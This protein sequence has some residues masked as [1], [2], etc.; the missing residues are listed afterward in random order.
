MNKYLSLFKNN[1]PRIK[2][3]SLYLS[4]SIVSGV[5]NVIF[6]PFLA[7]NLSSLDYSIIGY[8][9][10]F[11]SLFTPILNF[12]LISFYVR[13]YFKIPEE[14]RQLTLDTII[15]TLIIWGVI[16][17]ILILVLFYAYCNIAKVELPFFPFAVLVV[18]RLFF[19][20]F[21]LLYQVE[22]RMRREAKRYFKITILASLITILLSV[23]L[24]ILF[25][26]GAVGR[27]SAMLISSI[28]IGIFAIKKIHSKFKI[29]KSILKEAISFGWPVSC[30]YMIQYFLFGVDLALLE[31]LND[32]TNMGLYAI[33][34]SIV[35]YLSV[36]YIA[37]SQTFE[38]DIYKAVAQYNYKKIFYIEFLIV[39]ILLVIVLVFVLFAKP[40]IAVL[41]ANR[42]TNAYQFARILSIGVV[43]TYLMVAIEGI[44]NAFGFTKVCLINKIVGSALAIVLYFY[45]INS[46]GFYGGAWGRVAAPL[47]VFVI[48]CISLVL[49]KN[50]IKI[51]RYAEGK[52]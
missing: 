7:A 31:P 1:F 5:I 45:L 33:A 38:P 32:I 50:K 48:G 35:G 42:Y 13:K 39:S 37:L 17:S 30:S 51:M 12:S 44:I 11:G 41:T 22:C 16:S 2:N 24:V 15:T 8:Y 9:T 19:N 28:F 49:L 26:F 23:I 18:F 10:S 29:E 36:F 52:N 40:I 6:N 3:F 27:L 34:L 20:N 21:L 47:L 25:K 46:Y 4:A 14:K 43:S